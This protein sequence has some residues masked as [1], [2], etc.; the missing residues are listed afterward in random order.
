VRDVCNDLSSIL[1]WSGAAFVKNG[2]PG[3]SWRMSISRKSPA[4]D[5]G[6]QSELRGVSD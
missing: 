6:S 1:V 3:K 4:A 5:R 2:A